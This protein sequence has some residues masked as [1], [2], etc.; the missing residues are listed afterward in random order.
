MEEKVLTLNN[1]PKEEAWKMIKKYRKHYHEKEHPG[2]EYLSHGVWFS[3]TDL[4]NW[5]SQAKDCTGVRIYFATYLDN[6]P[7]RSQITDK[8]YNYKHRNTVVLIATKRSGNI[9][10]DQYL[11]VT[12]KLID[13]PFN[14]GELCPE[15]CGVVA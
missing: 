1:I 8:E 11:T 9:E 5:I 12:Q 15:E 3:F 4:N 6:E 2:A 10:E 7:H 13:S 14:K